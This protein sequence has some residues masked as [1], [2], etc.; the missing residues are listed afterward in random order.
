MGRTFFFDAQRRARVLCLVAALCCAAAPLRAQAEDPWA[1]A[2]VSVTQI[3]PVAGFEDPS[4]ALGKPVGASLSVPANT[5]V[6]SIGTQGSE[7]VLRFNTPVTDDPL[8]PMGLDCIVYGN[9]FYTGGNP[10]IKFIEA[11]LIEISEDVNNNGLA[12]DPWY[13]IPG[14]RDFPQSV[15]ST[16]L[17]NPTPPLAGSV[18]NPN[19]NG[20]EAD[21]GYADM[22][23]TQKEFRDN[24][25]RPDDP[26]TT[27]ITPG[28]GGGDAFD[29]AWARDAAGLPAGLTQFHFIRVRS[30][31]TGS[32][33][34]L[35]GVSPELDAV[36][37]VAP[38]VDSDGDGILD[39]Y[40]TRV[41]GT[42][43]L[44]PESTVIALEIPAEEGG[45]AAGVE[46]GSA[47]RADGTTLR[48]YS[49]GPRTGV[50][51]YN[52]FV[53]LPH[54]AAPGGMIPGLLLSDARCELTS[55]VADFQSA[56]VQDAELTLPYTS[57]A[58]AGLDEAAMTPWRSLPGGLYT[59]DGISLI[60]VDSANN[61]VSFRTRYAGTFV[62][63]GPAGSGDDDALPPA[64]P[65]AIFPITTPASAPGPLWF[66]TDTLLD[67]QGQPVADGTPITVVATGGR[68]TSMDTSFAGGHQ[69]AVQQG[70]LVF[71]VSIDDAQDPAPL[72]IDLY[73]DAARQ[74]QI[75][76][77]SFFFPVVPAAPMPLS[78][79]TA[80]FLFILVLLL[81]RVWRAPRVA[82]L[83]R[84]WRTGGGS[85][86]FTLIELLVVIAI[87]AILASILLPALSRARQQARAME[88]VSNLKQLYIAN[89]IYASE[90]G[91]RY[92]PAAPDMFDFTLPGADPEDFGGRIR[93]HGA[94]DTPNGT[95]SFDP[96]RGPLAE[97]LPDGRVKEC[98]VFSEFRRTEDAPNAFESGS[99]GYGYNMAYIGSMLSVNP[100]VVAAARKGML[101]VRIAEPAST[102]MFADA[103]LPQDGYIVEYGFLEPP[104]PVSAA[105][106][107]GK[108]GDENLLSPS[109]H[110]RH[111]GRANVLWADG[112]VTSEAWGWAPGENIYGARNSAFAVGWFGPRDN[113]LFDNGS[114]SAYTSPQ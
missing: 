2:V 98:P 110:F 14:S 106:P 95:T 21:W 70:V 30:F 89:V 55:N 36:A 38:L 34:S 6:V 92:V 62:L 47:V 68:V 25:L 112:H 50:R 108:P 32:L 80:V 53:D 24:Y 73:G 75:G 45:S 15:G 96:K 12:D 63:A 54:P 28:S 61:A 11:G 58:I 78:P 65:V 41:A 66:A 99:G 60:N 94:R 19:L 42:D 64:G 40:E 49:K 84:R 5:S 103:A 85:N 91:G 1:D 7:L 88:C 48:L 104:H 69:T 8:N 111:Y 72:T 10:R 20:D 31:L 107:H 81:F 102:I 113:R 97:Y 52:A 46:L 71:C 67:T 74:N 17:A 87:I 76:S 93:W 9:A 100:D 16:G 22:N 44:R 43:P 79:I 51:L 35:G 105:F 86:G 4:R 29:I 56:Q 3:A 26:F 90:A 57:A 27:G 82:A 59:Q 39:E 83:A 101:D 23:P 109:L 77:E 37:D 18:T 13:V 114:K 33:G